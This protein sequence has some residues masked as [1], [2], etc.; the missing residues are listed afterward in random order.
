[1]PSSSLLPGMKPAGS[2]VTQ[3]PTLPCSQLSVGRWSRRESC[4]LFLSGPCLGF[5]WSSTSSCFPV[6]LACCTFMPFAWV[7]AVSFLN[8]SDLKNPRCP[9][10]YSNAPHIDYFRYISTFQTFFIKRNCGLSDSSPKNS[11]SHTHPRVIPNLF[12]KYFEE[13]W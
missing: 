5:S 11:S 6:L 4:A 7:S 9:T 12:A 3:P 2:V 1:M 10:Q 8:F 13:C